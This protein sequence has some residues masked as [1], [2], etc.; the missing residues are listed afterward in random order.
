MNITPPG[1]DSFVLR[2]FPANDVGFA[3]AV[4]DAAS[5]MDALDPALIERVLR[6]RFPRVA[7]RPSV[8]QEYWTVWYVYREG[9]WTAA[10]PARAAGAEPARAAAAEPARA[11][12]AEPTRAAV[13]P[14]GGV[15]S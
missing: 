5:S 8:V 15:R 6:D 1:L 12:A 2:T 11:A 13:A 10:E 9:R 4:A 3:R 14:E 7:V